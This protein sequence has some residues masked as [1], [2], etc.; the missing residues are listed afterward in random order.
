VEKYG[1]MYRFWAG[2]NPMVAISSPELMEPILSN[3]QLMNKPHE[4]SFMNPFLGDSIL[5]SKG[6]KWISRRRLLNPAFH[7]QIINTFVGVF[8]EHSSRCADVIEA[9][10]IDDSRTGHFNILPIIT[11]C[12]LDTFCGNYL[13]ICI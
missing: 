10:L 8:N 1:V 9:S 2:T 6:D 4:Y 12:L 3:R 11:K 13:V 5:V 7:Y